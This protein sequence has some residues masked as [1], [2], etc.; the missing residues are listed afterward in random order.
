[1]I[2]RAENALFPYDRDRSH[3]HFRPFI[4]IEDQFHGVGGGDA[5]VGRLYRG[6]L[7]PVRGQQAFDHHFGARDFRGIELAFDRKPDFLF[8]E[9]IEN[10]RLGNRFVSLV[11]DAADDGPLGDVENDD[12]PVR[13]GR[14]RLPLRAGCPRRIA[15]SRAPGNRGA[16]LLRCKDRPAREKMRASN[17]SRCTRRF[18]MNSIRVM[19]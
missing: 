17:V 13:I 5:L 7:V 15:C 16:P 6:E 19:T 14:D 3:F 12:F 8:L 10:V 9:R 1:M 18:P 2:L 4:N 11:F